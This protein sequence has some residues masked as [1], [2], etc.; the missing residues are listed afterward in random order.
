[1]GG[2]TA[3]ALPAVAAGRKVGTSIENFFRGAQWLR[4]VKNGMTPEMAAN[5][6]NKLHFNYGDLSDFESNVM[7]RLVPFYTFTRKNLPLQASN[8]ATRP[9]LFNAQYKPFHQQTPGEDGY[10]PKYMASGVS[11]PL[12][13][14]VDGKRQYISKL[15]LPA[16][17]ALERLHF[18]NGL[19]DIRA[20][21]LDYMGAMNPLIKAPLEQLFNTQFHSQRKLSD[22][23]PSASATAIGK[24]FNEDN[25]Q[26]LSQV[27]ANSPISRFVTSVDKIADHRKSNLQKA[28]N[29]L[30]GVRIT[31]VDAD[32][33]RA[34][35]FRNELEK[36][37]EGHKSLS[38]YSRY[39]V[40]PENAE[41]LTPEE[42]RYMRAYSQLGD[43]GRAYA[44]KKR[45]EIGIKQ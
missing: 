5:E 44:K 25:P 42:I 14:E 9:G 6:I 12:G 31:D 35:E 32:K 11:I 4:E 17:E 21:A 36:L 8:I 37:M 41:K 40:K 7:R 30:T 19:P 43:Q 29:M 22:L 39:Y 3:D 18:Q 15:G 20:T 2:A 10:V 1:V 45:A 38:K 33:Q 26:L 24:V 16:E 13:P 27:L 23:T 28:V 34:I